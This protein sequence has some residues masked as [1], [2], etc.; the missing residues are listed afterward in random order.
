[1]TVRRPIRRA[2]LAVLAVLAAACA[3]EPAADS[4]TDP[5]LSAGG[6]DLVF[7]ALDRDPVAVMEALYT[8]TVTLDA[9]GCLRLDGPD[10]ATVVWPH[11]FSADATAAAIAIRD[12][13]G[14]VVGR[15]GE[16]FALGGGIVPSL[17]EGIPM[18]S[19]DRALGEDACP[20]DYWIVGDVQ[21]P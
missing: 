14:R 18:R 12:A 6:A 13:G 3:G 8:G 7:L 20:G 4:G 5:A 21:A 11:G 17:H 16:D 1:M 15:V 9:A 19:S 2:P 10:A